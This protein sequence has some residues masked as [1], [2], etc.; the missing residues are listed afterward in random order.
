MK[1]VPIFTILLCFK[2]NIAYADSEL[3][4][5]PTHWR[6]QEYVPGLIATWYTGITNCGTDGSL[7]LP[8]NATEETKQRY[9]YLIMSAKISQKKVGVF[10]NNINGVCTIISFYLAEE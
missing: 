6:L 7:R 10:Y 3:Q 1:M 8:N 4:T 9:W 2:S 5:Y